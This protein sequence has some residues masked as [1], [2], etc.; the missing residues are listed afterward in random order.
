MQ[1]ITNQSRLAFLTNQGQDVSYDFPRL[2]L[3]VWFV[4]HLA[5]QSGNFGQNVKSYDSFGSTDRKIFEMTE[6][7]E[8]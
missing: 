2:V 4:Y 6:R 3:V 8:R 5:K 7:L 1:H